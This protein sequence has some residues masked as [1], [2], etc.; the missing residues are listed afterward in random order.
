VTGVEV[1]VKLQ[2]VG[3][4]RATPHCGLYIKEVMLVHVHLLLL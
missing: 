2:I 1:C 4:V 3:R